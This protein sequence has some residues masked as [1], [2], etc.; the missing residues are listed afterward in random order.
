MQF[1]DSNWVVTVTAWG[2]GRSLFRKILEIVFRRFSFCPTS[3]YLCKNCALFCT[4]VLTIEVTTTLYFL[5]QLKRAWTHASDWSAFYK[6][7]DWVRAWT[8]SKSGINYKTSCLIYKSLYQHP[9]NCK[10]YKRLQ[11]RQTAKNSVIFCLA[12]KSIVVIL[13]VLK[14]WVV[15]V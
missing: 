11:L 15:N 2:G 5:G 14:S 13:S 6:T 12:T 1:Y 3:N 7:W 4:C 9:P 10:K 8:R